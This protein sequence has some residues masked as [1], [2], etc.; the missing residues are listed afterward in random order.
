M[1]AVS[2]DDGLRCFCDY[3]PGGHWWSLEQGCTRR[4][5]LDQGD[6]LRDAI[7][8]VVSP[9]EMFTADDG[10]P[11]IRQREQRSAIEITNTVLALPEVAALR[12]KAA[13]ADRVRELADTYA[14]LGATL[15]DVPRAETWTEAATEL[16]AALDGPPC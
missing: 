1:T 7:E 16:R 8:R 9:F 5:V 12:A 4:P 10:Q 3:N 11:S 13:A 15:H 6:P 2:G 14:F